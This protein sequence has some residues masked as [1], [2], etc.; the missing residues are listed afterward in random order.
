VRG[1][2][3]SGRLHSRHRSGATPP[4]IGQLCAA[5]PSSLSSVTSISFAH[6]FSPL[7]R[8]RLLAS[9][10]ASA[11]PS[12]FTYRCSRFASGG[13]VGFASPRFVNVRSASNRARNISTQ[14]RKSVPP[15][16]CEDLQSGTIQ[17]VGIAGVTRKTKTV[18]SRISASPVYACGLG[19]PP[20]FPRVIL[21]EDWSFQNTS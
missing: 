4:V 13:S 7:N 20:V 6:S 8:V 9:T 12:E 17:N 18:T 14:P 21:R 5:P 2:Q 11:L 19:L 10:D 16:Q 15:A 3:L 1:S